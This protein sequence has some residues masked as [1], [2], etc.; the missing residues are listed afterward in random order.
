MPSTEATI[1]T[2]RSLRAPPPET[3]PDGRPDAERAQELERVAQAVGDALEHS[4][5]ER[6]A[7][8]AQREAGER[9]ANVRIGVRGA[10]ALQVRRE[11]QALGARLPAGGLLVELP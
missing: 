9:A 4:T 1:R 11:Q 2:Q 6:A 10:L 8:V 3:R 5:C 7:I